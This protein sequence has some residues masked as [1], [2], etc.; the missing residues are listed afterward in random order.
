MIEI[1]NNDAIGYNRI[2]N[3]DAWTVANL[4]SCPDTC[5][6]RID[7][8]QKHFETDEVFILQ[9]GNATLIILESDEFNIDKLKFIRLEPNKLYNVKKNTYHQHVLDENSNLLIVE[10]SNTSDDL[11]SKRIYL[12]DKQKEEFISYARSALNV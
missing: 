6:E 4:S 3:Y 2:I 11:N 1:K 10:N 5:I 8:F 12:T 9:K 7:S